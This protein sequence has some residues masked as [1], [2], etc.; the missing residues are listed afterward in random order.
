MVLEINGQRYRETGS[1]GI[2]SGGSKASMT[3]EG[4]VVLDLQPGDYAI[5]LLWFRLANSDRVWYCGST[6]LDGFGMGRILAAIGDPGIEHASAYDLKQ[7]GQLQVGE[8]S[9]VG[10]SVLGF[11]LPVGSY[12]TLSYNL[13][14]AQ[15]DNPQFATWS[16]SKW[17]RI[18]TRLI[19]DGIAYRHLS[20]YV[21]G[22]V[23]GIKHAKASM[24]LPLGAGSH[25]V[26]LQW[27]NVDG[28]KWRSVSFITDHASAY[29]SVFVSINA[30]NNDPRVQGPTE[31]IGQEDLP[32]VITSISIGDNKESM[33]LDYE[34]AVR[35]SV[36]HGVLSAPRTPGVTYASGNGV[37]DEF[38]LFSGTLSSVNA[39]L[40]SITY[41]AFL[42]WYGDDQLSIVVSEQASTGFGA[43]SSDQKVISLHIRSVND[44]PRLSVPSAQALYED[45]EVT[46]FGVRVDDVDT[47]SGTVDDCVF[48]V[49]LYVLGGLL[50]LETQPPQLTFLEGD[51]LRN[52]ICRFKGPIDAVNAALFEIHYEPNREFNSNHH[53]ERIGISVTDYNGRD[54]TQT[55]ATATI[56]LFVQSVDDPMVISVGQRLSFT[57]SGYDVQMHPSLTADAKLYARLQTMTPFG[58]LQLDAHIKDTPAEVERLPASDAP[59]ISVQLGGPLQMVKGLLKSITYVRVQPFFG[60]EV[61][62]VAL[63]HESDF[64][65]SEES[66]IELAMHKNGTEGLIV[67]TSVAPTT[68]SSSGGTKVR[69]TGRGFSRWPTGTL[70]CLFGANSPTSATIISDSELECRTPSNRADDKIWRP[71]LTYA[72]VTNG[73]TYYS[74]PV[75]FTYDAEWIVTSVSPASGPVIGGTR[76]V[77]EGSRFPNIPSL[78]CFFGTKSSRASFLSDDKIACELPPSDLPPRVVD[79]RLTTNRQEFSGGLP[80]SYTGAISV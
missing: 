55:T 73:D 8:W 42:N 3:L 20:S 54:N 77:V 43:T 25:T 7:F 63:S 60:Y 62:F 6:A 26:R 9:D 24:V 17:S 35:V 37:R 12:V 16:T 14:L 28:S 47:E 34:V 38:L 39:L 59:S 21:D 58:R 41:E 44:P 15:M 11:S 53:A 30:W 48:E 4:S 64:T 72:M 57:I 80:F 56:P 45:D 2:L 19:V 18:Q 27:Q 33:A 32:L 51:G 23:R 36:Q 10:D 65:H 67:L 46:V 79:V 76:V 71:Q 66:M 22:D 74:N 40:S 68:G 61:V 49:E 29:A 52:Q 31:L 5:A 75:L 70:K 78:E 1:Y 69:F 50:S 13:P